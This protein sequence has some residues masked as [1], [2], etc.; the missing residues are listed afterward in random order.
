MSLRLYE[1]SAYKT[2][3]EKAASWESDPEFGEYYRS[4]LCA[5][6]V[7]TAQNKEA[8]LRT[9]FEHIQPHLHPDETI[10]S[11]V[12]AV[13]SPIC[14]LP[15]GHCGKCSFTPHNALFRELPDS[16][17]GKVDTSIYSTPGNDDFVYKNRSN[18]LFPIAL[19]G[20]Q[21]SLIRNK[22]E[23]LKCAIPLCDATTPLMQASAHI[24]W[25]T[26]CVNVPE[27]RR[28]LSDI[29]DE[30]AFVKMLDA[31]KTVL[32]DR[33]RRYRRQL[34]NADGHTI[35]PVTAHQIRLADLAS[36]DDSRTNPRPTDIQLGHCVPRSDREFTIRGF[37][38][39]MMTR[40]GNRIVGDSPFCSDEWVE[41]L[42]SIVNFQN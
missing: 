13:K 21:E 8:S 5:K 20:E 17:S 18:R 12:S 27:I 22:K 1:N 25:I 4:I 35:C 19:S 30:G 38:I 42:R 37:N 31:H 14:V 3:N 28:N 9:A 39:C 24:D 10:E 11:V 34:F 40:E 41:R 32:N 26:Q 6:P 33:F 7:K 36:R 23:Q 2:C 15:K 29:G 16:L